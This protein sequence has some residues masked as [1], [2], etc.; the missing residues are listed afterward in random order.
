MGGQDQVSTRTS[1]RVDTCAAVVTLQTLLTRSNASRDGPPMI[2]S[3]GNEIVGQ[4]RAVI[5]EFRNK[6]IKSGAVKFTALK[7]MS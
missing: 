6:F 3:H 4:D 2:G 7:V 1:T 5:E